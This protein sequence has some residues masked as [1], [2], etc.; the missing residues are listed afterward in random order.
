[1]SRD[2]NFV[3]DLRY[4]SATDSYLIPSFCQWLSVHRHI[5]LI[6]RLG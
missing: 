1:M 2:N 6:L 3:T 4:V 5:T